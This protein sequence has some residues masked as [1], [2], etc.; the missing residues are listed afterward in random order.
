MAI[1]IE[2]TLATRYS[3]WVNL[4]RI[5]N[6]INSIHAQKPPTKMNL[7]TCCLKID[8]I[9]SK[10]LIIIDEYSF[11][12]LIQ[13]VLSWNSSNFLA[14]S[15]FEFVISSKSD[16]INDFGLGLPSD[17]SMYRRLSLITFFWWGEFII[18]VGI[19]NSSVPQQYFRNLIIFGLLL[20][21]SF[22]Y[23]AHSADIV[24]QVDLF[25]PYT[26]VYSGNFLAGVSLLRILSAKNLPLK[27]KSVKWYFS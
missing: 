14:K 8:R 15:I 13:D 23:A 19:T 3:I 12:N 18:S 5:L 4:I 11:V 25:P 26:L 6:V 20:N 10:V 22:I 27:L 1:T 24:H 9:N 2:I 7:N 21:F 16:N 17:Q